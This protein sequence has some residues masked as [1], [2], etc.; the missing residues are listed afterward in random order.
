MNEKRIE[1]LLSDMPLAQPTPDLDERILG[2]AEADRDRWRLVSWTSGLVGVAAGLAIALSVW[3]VLQLTAS[4]GAPALR[5]SVE[6]ASSAE[7][8]PAADTEGTVVET[9]NTQIVDEGMVL[10]DN[11]IPLHQIRRVT[12]R[13]VMYYNE[14][15]NERL[16]L[17]EPEEEVILIAAETF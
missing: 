10:V 17:I 7:T 1:E 5:P 8:A 6:L 4:S 3:G 12:T 2:I 13:Q 11:N 15:T 16:E 14:K 9:T